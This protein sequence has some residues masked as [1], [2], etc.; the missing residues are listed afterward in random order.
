MVSNVPK[1]RPAYP[2]EFRQE[3][4]QMLR[5]AGD[6]LTEAELT[7]LHAAIPDT[8][9]L[10]ASVYDGATHLGSLIHGPHHWRRV[11]LNGCELIEA[12]EAANPAVVFAFALLH[13][14][15]RLN[16]GHD[17]Q[18][19]RRAAM[20]ARGLSRHLLSLSPDERN[21]LYEACASHTKAGP[22]HEPTLGVC[23]DSDRLDLGRV[24]I[25]PHPAYLS[26]AT[27]RG[28][29]GHVRDHSAVPEWPALYERFAAL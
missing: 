8:D 13:D 25:A 24:G 26:T 4:V 7:T 10:V 22:T 1:A 19:G 16:D 23:F 20:V 5:A 21:L 27:A 6:E 9:A 3:A 29:T 12:G 18:H 15:Q 28:W 2:P 17:P 11:A 14:S